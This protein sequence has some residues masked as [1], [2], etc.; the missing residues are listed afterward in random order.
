MAKIIVFSGHGS[1]Q[2]GKDEFVSLPPRCS[3]RFYTMNMR[4]LSDAFGGDLDQGLLDGVEPDQEAG[5]FQHV[6]DMRLYPP[7]GLNIRRP[8][9]GWHEIQLPTA[10]PQ[11]N[12][13]IQVTIK[14]QYGG[15]GSLSTLFSLL[16]PAIH[17]ADEVIFV[18]AACRAIN[19]KRTARGRAVQINKMQ[20]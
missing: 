1:W 6:P 11:D 19:L 20:R 15:G 10:V 8:P 17:R 2:L 5:P 16:D 13:N 7:T 12:A 14:P 3:M 4:T 9:N 18:W